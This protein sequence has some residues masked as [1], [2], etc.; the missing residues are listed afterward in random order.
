[1]MRL[2]NQ[3]DIEICNRSSRINCTCDHLHQLIRGNTIAH[4]GIEESREGLQKMID[5]RT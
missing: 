1:M 5:I 3:T 4:A 2:T